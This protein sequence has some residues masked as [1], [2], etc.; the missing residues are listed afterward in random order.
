MSNLVGPVCVLH[1]Y[2]SASADVREANLRHAALLS[3]TVNYLGAATVSI[4]H[5]QIWRKDIFA[6]DGWYEHAMVIMRAC[7]SVV[8]PMQHVRSGI[9]ALAIPEACRLGIPVFYATMTLRGL[10]SDTTWVLESGFLHWVAAQRDR[11]DAS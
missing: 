9:C 3:T 1:P 2:G 8:M 7:S 5:E 6:Y 11:R 4:L 10:G